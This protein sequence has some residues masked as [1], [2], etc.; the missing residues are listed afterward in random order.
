M[1]YLS[2]LVRLFNGGAHT[3]WRIFV[4]LERKMNTIESVFLVE[5]RKVRRFRFKIL[6]FCEFQGLFWNSKITKSGEKWPHSM[7]AAV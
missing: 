3:V 4:V 6:K 1:H 5:M 2:A 7:G